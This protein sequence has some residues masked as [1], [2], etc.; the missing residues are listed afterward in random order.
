MT[1]NKGQSDRLVLVIH[2]HKHIFLLFPPLYPILI[3][4]I[5]P[6]SGNF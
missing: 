3:G 4:D 2:D 1:I 6:N 5:D